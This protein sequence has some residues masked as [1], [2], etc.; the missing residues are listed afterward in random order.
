MEKWKVIFYRAIG[1]VHIPEHIKNRKEEIILHISDTPYSF[2]YSLKKL[3]QKIKPEYIIHTGDLVD[4]IK[5]QFY[6][7]SLFRYTKNLKT[8]VDIFEN[9]SAK[10][11]YISLGNHDKKEAVQG[12]SKRVT[13]I[14]KSDNIRIGDLN[15]RISHYSNEI[16]SNPLEY[17]L[18]GHDLSIK[19][20]ID[21]GKIY[22]NGIESINIININTGDITKLPYPFG[23]D[24]D[25][26]GKGNIGL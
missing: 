6:Q 26:L 20:K 13:I 22:L 24:D 25:R 12:L 5:L 18:F 10:K 15:L 14:E 17:N 4:N 11:I 1:L 3:I 19:N 7:Y 16:I 2:F 23:I 21:N 8:L 9:S